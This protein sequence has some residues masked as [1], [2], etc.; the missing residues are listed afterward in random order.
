MDI[1]ALK[2]TAS[3]QLESAREAKKIVLIYAGITIGLS[4]LVTVVNYLAGNGI[5]Q[6]GGL[7]NMGL[8]AALSTLQSVLPMVQSVLLMIVELGYINAALRIGRGQYAS[9]NSL[10]MGLDRF[11]PLVR[12]TLVEGFIYFLAGMAGF[13]LAVQIFVITPLSREALDILMPLMENTTILNSTVLLDEQTVWLLA[14]AMTPMFVLCAVICAALCIPLMYSFRM[15]KYVLIDKPHLGG[16]AVLRESRKMMRK[17]RLQLLK[18]DLSFWWY[19]LLLFG[20]GVPCYGDVV[21]G[22]L[23]ITLPISTQISYLLFYLM[24]LAVTLMIYYFFR[25][26]IQV[27]YALAYE[28]FKPEEKQ[29]NSVVLGNIF[30]M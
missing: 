25:N 16:M 26:Q 15:A 2:D 24:F 28:Q 29:D 8:R 5:S 12:L 20:A 30:Q 27:S 23:G 7:S 1:R 3:R 6:T 10:R 9:V 21:L 19:Y 18:L 11:F 22:W 14:E 13:Y 17:R 4:A